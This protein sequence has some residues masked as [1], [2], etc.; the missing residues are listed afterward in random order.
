MT[1]GWGAHA[2][3]DWKYGSNDGFNSEKSSADD[4]VGGDNLDV[5]GS[6]WEVYAQGPVAK[7]MNLKFGHFQPGLQSGYVS[8][9]RVY[10]AEVDYNASD[11]TTVK[12]YGGKIREKKWSEMG[13]KGCNL[14]IETLTN[15]LYQVNGKGAFTGRYRR[16]EGIPGYPDRSWRYDQPCSSSSPWNGNL[17]CIRMR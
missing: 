8:N 13:K 12:A 2:G 4:Y 15:D 10:G 5:A 3:L 6:I 14:L 1:N 11:N 16:Y 9:A 7:N 17:L